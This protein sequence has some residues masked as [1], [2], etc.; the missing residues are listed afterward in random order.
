M[1]DRYNITQDGFS[2]AIKEYWEENFEQE[3]GEYED[4]FSDIDFDPFGGEY[5][6]FLDD[7][8]DWLGDYFEIDWEDPFDDLYYHDPFDDIHCWEDPPLQN[9]N[10]DIETRDIECKYFWIWNCE[11]NSTPWW[12]FIHGFE[13][14]NAVLVDR[15]NDY[16]EANN[17]AGQVQFYYLKNLIA[18]AGCDP[19]SVDFEH[20]VS[21]TYE[22]HR[23][24]YLQGILDNLEHPLNVEIDYFYEATLDC[25]LNGQES[26]DGCVIQKVRDFWG[27]I[28]VFVED[29]D[30]LYED[31][32][33]NIYEIIDFEC[34]VEVTFND[35]ALAS[36][37]TFWIE[38]LKQV[39]P[40]LQI[41]SH[42]KS[43]PFIQTN[44]AYY[45]QTNY[46]NLGFWHELNPTNWVAFCIPNLCIQVPLQ[47]TSGP[48]NIH[49]V[50]RNTVIACDKA[51]SKLLEFVWDGIITTPAEGRIAFLA[52]FRKELSKILGVTLGSV[53]INQVECNNDAGVADYGVN[54][55]GLKASPKECVYEE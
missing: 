53:T 47:N 41:P 40:E 48:F 10:N 31:E 54:L 4:F 14:E 44:Q 45:C 9:E 6:Q 16:F 12:I 51:R 26:F 24:T 46:I 20:C 3:Y 19:F 25:Y 43:F 22:T 23:K 29:Y 28:D 18:N 27:L 17:L 34:D 15:L 38:F 52:E 13:D 1:T 11:L 37:D 7:L 8:Y 33:F 50:P 2:D 30:L 42:S 49:D 35:C 21:Y 36:I 39:Y 5:S 55:L 32:Y